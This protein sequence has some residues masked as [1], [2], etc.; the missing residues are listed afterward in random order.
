[1]NKPATQKGIKAKEKIFQKS[2]ELFK[3]KGYVQT[4][5]G[6]ICKEAGIAN[7]TFYHYFKS[8][9]DICVNHI[10]QE[11]IRLRDYYSSLVISSYEEALVGVFKKQLESCDTVGQ[12]FYKTMF[13]AE[14]SSNQQA[15]HLVA[16]TS[17]DKTIV[18]CIRKG[19]EINEF[20]KK[21]SAEHFTSLFI[22]Q[23]TLHTL[24]WSASEK[25]YDLKEKLLPELKFIINLL[26]Y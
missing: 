12:E 10:K 19:Q 26:K 24:K 22:G 9:Q 8:K 20:S 5:L 16:D 1:M 13:I 18:E 21:H 17:L 15:F 14:L 2:L 6:D 4:T 7:G 11:S 25:H 23:I 3:E